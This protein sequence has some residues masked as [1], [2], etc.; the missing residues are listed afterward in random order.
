MLS[1]LVK[2]YCSPEPFIVEG[3]TVVYQLMKIS[4]DI[5]REGSAELQM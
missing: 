3:S 2:A 4:N 1:R 5:Q